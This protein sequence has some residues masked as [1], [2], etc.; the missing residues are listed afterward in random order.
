MIGYD[1]SVLVF[2][3]QGMAGS[4]IIRTLKEKGF[5]NI[6]AP[7]RQ[8]VDLLDRQSVF[9]YL[10]ETDAGLLIMAAAKVGGIMANK[11]NQAGFFS[12]NMQMELNVIDSAHQTGIQHLIFL[13]IQKRA[14]FQRRVF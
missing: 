1:E 9:N 4:A 5:T 12:Q 6:L 10:N 8:E 3:G 2:G 13:V 11:N 7:P 14:E